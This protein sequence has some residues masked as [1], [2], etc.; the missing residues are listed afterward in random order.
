MSNLNKQAKMMLYVINK[1]RPD[2]EVSILTISKYS[3]EKARVTSSYRVNVK[4]NND[5]SMSGSIVDVIYHLKAL[6]NLKVGDK[7]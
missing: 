3:K 6:T 1:N 2:L 7:L 5:L 4:H